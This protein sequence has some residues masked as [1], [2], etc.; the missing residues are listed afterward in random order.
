MID[1]ELPADVVA[2]RDRVQTFIAHKIVPYE[3][4]IRQTAHGAPEPLRREL[5][6]LARSPDCCRRT[7]RRNTV[8]LARSSRHGGGL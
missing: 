7:R 2:L 6:A 4:D 8:A 1:F 5:V 3:N